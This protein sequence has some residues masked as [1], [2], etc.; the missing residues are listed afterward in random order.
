MAT[1]P[2]FAYWPKDNSINMSGNP[3]IT[4]IIVNGI[5]NAPAKKKTQS[6]IYTVTWAPVGFA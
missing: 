6:Y 3:A 5:R 1:G 2:R 4:S